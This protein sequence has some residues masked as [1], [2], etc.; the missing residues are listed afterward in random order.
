MIPALGVSGSALSM[1]LSWLG[2]VVD[3]LGDCDAKTTGV[4][5]V[6]LGFIE[7]AKVRSTSR[8]TLIDSR[9]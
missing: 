2:Q 7:V 3:W 9:A 4:R 1:S 8:R 6:T 5:S